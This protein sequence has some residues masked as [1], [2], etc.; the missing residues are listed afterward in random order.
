[1]S[2]PYYALVLGDR[3]F[4]I[5]LFY[6]ILLFCLYL[7]KYINKLV[8]FKKVC[9]QNLQLIFL[10]ILRTFDL[11]CHDQTSVKIELVMFGVS[12]L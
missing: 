9:F 8:T 12:Y 1:M 2:S 10:V 5:L 11:E 6:Q 7:R 3:P 4:L